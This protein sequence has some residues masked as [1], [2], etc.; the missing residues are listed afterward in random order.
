LTGIF[1]WSG[2]SGVGISF[3]AD[4]IYDVLEHFD[5]FPSDLEVATDVLVC[6]LDED[7]AAVE[8]DLATLRAFRTAGWNSELYPEAT[9]LK[10]QLKFAA[11]RHIPW[12]VI[13]G[14]SEREQGMITLRNM[15]SG[16][17]SILTLQSAIQAVETDRA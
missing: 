12:V 17:Q 6:R 7:D 1:G 11:D 15:A 14:E 13:C 2:M 9:K 5:A 4:R 16:E 10:K 3:G 8:N